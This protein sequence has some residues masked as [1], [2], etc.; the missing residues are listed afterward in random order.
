MVNTLL[1]DKKISESGLKIDYIVQTLGISRQ[2]FAKK[3]SNDIPFRAAEI[4]V[5]CD[6]LNIRD[7]AE[8][9]DIFF[10]DE[11]DTKANLAEETT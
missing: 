1:L 5:I 11:V 2:A 4:Y 6:L 8:K 10:T 3:R 9:K 7:A